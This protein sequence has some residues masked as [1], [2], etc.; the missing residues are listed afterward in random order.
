MIAPRALALAGVQH[1]RL[2]AHLFP[3]DGLEAAAVLLCSQTAGSSPRL[4]VQEILEVPHEVC[5]LR[6]PDFLAWPG[7]FIERALDRAEPSNLTLVLMHSHPGA[8]F[9]FSTLDDTSDQELMRSALENHGDFHCSAIMVPDGAIRA[10]YYGRD[11][12]ARPIELVTVVGDDILLWWAVDAVL[13]IPTSRPMAFTSDMTAE[14][15]RL[16]AMVIG[17]S[18]TG[19]LAAEQALRLGFK[20]VKLV[21]FDR[22]ELKNINRIVNSKTVD[23]KAARLKVEMFAEAGAEFRGSDAVE[24]IP[25]SILTRKAVLAASQCDVLFSCVDSLE[26]R[27]VLDLIGATFLLPLFDVGVSIP[28]R[29]SR[30]KIAIGDVCGRIDYVQPGRSTLGDRGVYTP[31]S[32]RAEYLRQ[33]AP[34]AH[35]AELDAGYL[36]GMIEEAPS[37]ISLN[38][39]ASAALMNEFI[40]RTYP[41][42]HEPNACFARTRFSLAAAEEEYFPEGSF[43]TRSST[44]LG[45]GQQEPLLGLP[46]LAAFE[47]TA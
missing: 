16:T 17:V 6:R 20:Q 14:L 41:F 3:G 21:D 7:E 23:A 1:E 15:N 13:G 24:A 18:G 5:R 8:Q 38:M 19:S 44:S 4:M 28:T 39:R 35:R 22:M 32:L 37:V 46:C 11:L 43:Q 25:H 33:N 2:R 31:E 36:K 26:A 40:A 45:R 10:R 29:T 9:E 47:A 30:A 12:N 42:R 34:D 27:Q